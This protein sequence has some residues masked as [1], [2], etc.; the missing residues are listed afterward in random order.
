MH[1]SEGILSAPV[2]LAGA[3]GAIAGLALGLRR[4]EPEAIPKTALLTAAFFIAS[5]IHVPVGPSSSHLVLNGLLGILLGWTA[6]PAIFTGLILQAVLFQFGGLTTLGV[7]TLNIALPGVLAG[8]AVRPLLR[9][10]SPAIAAASATFAGGGAIV[11]SGAMTAASL[12][13]SGDSFLMAGRLIFLAH[14]PVA[15]LEGVISA[16]VLTFLLRVRPEIV[17]RPGRRTGPAPRTLHCALWCGLAVL[18]SLSGR[19]DAHRVNIFAWY[20]GT[21]IRGEGYFAGGQP[22]MNAP[23]EVYGPS[24]AKAFE[25]TTDSEGLFAC[26]PET[27]GEYRLVLKAGPGHAAETTVAAG[28]AGSGTAPGIHLPSPP[29]GD[30]KND[31]AAGD[32]IERLLDRKLDPI[33]TELMK[34]ARRD[35][36]VHARDVAA[37]LGYIAGLVGLAMYMASRDR[38][39][40]PGQKDPQR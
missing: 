19:A 13:L 33:R 32:D 20:D 14:I 17:P 5:L 34:I 28:D 7:N 31:R 38:R 11:L 16:L 29:R 18:L 2:L 39:R 12:A 26:R 36:G 30:G 10:D 21:Q 15:A 4:M 6:F 27:P 8:L 40:R 22:A 23:V 9:T 1:I 24:G 3:G 25:V 35:E 37:G